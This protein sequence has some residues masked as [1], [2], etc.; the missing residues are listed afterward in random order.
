[1]AFREPFLGQV[2]QPEPVVLRLRL[3]APEQQETL[4]SVELVVVEAVVLEL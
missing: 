4:E 3:V 1:V 2:V